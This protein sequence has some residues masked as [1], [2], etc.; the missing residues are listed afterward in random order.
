[1]VRELLLADGIGVFDLGRLRSVDPGL[2][3]GRGVQ[4]LVADSDLADAIEMVA[5]AEAS[6][7]L[8]HFPQVADY[9]A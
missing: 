1:M 3:F 2:S 5:Q 4:L 9:S 6:P 8:R 7:S